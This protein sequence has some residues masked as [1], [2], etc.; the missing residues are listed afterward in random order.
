[1]IKWSSA[2]VICGALGAAALAG[3]ARADEVVS[4]SRLIPN[5]S[6]CL[7]VALPAGEDQDKVYMTGCGPD[8]SLTQWAVRPVQDGFHIVSLAKGEGF[9]LEGNGPLSP[10]KG[11]ASFMTPCAQIGGQV[12]HVSKRKPP[13]ALGET[14]VQLST[15]NEPERCLE[16]M[17][18][19]KDQK[20]P[21]ATMQPCRDTPSQWFLTS[22]S[23]L[24]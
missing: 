17:W 13:N 2:V 21:P 18:N 5:G 8:L 20:G 7:V 16:A 10:V 12:W 6:G 15:F 1:M 22:G 4:F 19:D 23:N 3:P 9:C 14:E 24:Q 11:G